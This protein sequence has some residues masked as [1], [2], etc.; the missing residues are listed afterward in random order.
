MTDKR[1]IISWETANGD[2]I[3]VG[4]YRLTP[5]A[6]SLQIQTR[7]GGFVWNQPA[8]V[9]VDRNGESENLPIVDVTRLVQIILWGLSGIVFVL[10]WMIRSKK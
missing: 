1:P 2:P 10:A 8:G 3:D 7:W 6:R 4:S 5:Q 9:I